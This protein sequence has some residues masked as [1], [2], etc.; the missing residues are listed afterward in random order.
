LTDQPLEGLFDGPGV[1]ARVEQAPPELGD[2]QLAPA[3]Q[4][5]AQRIRLI[6]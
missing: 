5:Q 2:R 1:A 3:E 6:G 4:S